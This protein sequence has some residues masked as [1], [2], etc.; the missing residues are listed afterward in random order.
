MPAQFNDFELFYAS[1]TKIRLRAVFSVLRNFI[2]SKILNLRS[3]EFINTSPIR[4]SRIRPGVIGHVYVRTW[5]THRVAIAVVT[6]IHSFSTY[7]PTHLRTYIHSRCTWS[8]ID[9]IGHNVRAI[10]NVFG[11]VIK[12]CLI[13]V[14]LPRALSLVKLLMPCFSNHIIPDKILPNVS[15]ECIRVRNIVAHMRPYIYMM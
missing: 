13:F 4:S 1:C 6:L 11:S 15:R 3:H 5:L 8:S 2:Y 7:G 12:L 9:Q 14:L 10:V